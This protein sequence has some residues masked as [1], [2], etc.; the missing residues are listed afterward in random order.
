MKLRKRVLRLIAVRNLRNAHE[1]GLSQSFHNC[2]SGGDHL[3]SEA[4]STGWLRDQDVN[5]KALTH[6]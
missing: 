5:L 6:A 1:R 3:A 2:K 4:E